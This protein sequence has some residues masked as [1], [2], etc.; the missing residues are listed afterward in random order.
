MNIN[1]KKSVIGN[2][3]LYP[4]LTGNQRFPYLNQR[5]RRAKP[6]VSKNPSGI[7]VPKTSSKARCFSNFPL[8]KR[9]GRKGQI[10]IFIILG[11]I[12][13]ISVITVIYIRG[14]AVKK[15]AEVE[16]VLEEVP[17]WVKPVQRYVHSCM[18]EVAIKAFKKIGEHGGY[19]DFD[20]Y[21]IVGRN[22]NINLQDPTDSDAVSLS[23]Q[24]SSPVAYWWYMSTPN[25]CDNCFVDSLM[26]TLEDVEQ[27][28]NRYINKELLICLDNFSTFRKQNFVFETGNI[29]TT[30]SV[31]IND[32]SV[33][34]N[35]PV[36]V[37]LADSTISMENFRINLD[38][39]FFRNFLLASLIANWEMD[40]QFLEEMIMY[41][42]TGYSSA[43]D[44]DRIPPISWID[45]EDSFVTWD[46]GKVKEVINRD[47]LGSNIPLI[48]V[49][50][51]GGATHVDDAMFLDFLNLNFPLQVSFFYDPVWNY[52]LD[53]TPSTGNILKPT[54]STID[55]PIGFFPEV[56]TNYYEFFYDVSF[57]VIVI[58]RDD[59]SL[60]AHGEKGYT[61]MFALEGNIRDNK[62]LYLWNQGR[63]TI[64]PMDYSGVSVSVGATDSSSTAC[65]QVDIESDD[66][67]TAVEW[68]CPLN[69]QDYTDFMACSSDCI[70]TTTS[71]ISP[72]RMPSLFCEHEQRI[73]GN[74]TIRTF[75]AE[76]NNP[77]P[78]VPITFGCGNYRKCL[79]GVTNDGGVYTDKF[80]MCV[81]SGY[82]LFDKSNY[83]SEYL[84]DI[85]I[86]P[87]EPGSYNVYLEPIVGKEVDAYFINVTNM[88]RL[89]RRLLP[90][91]GLGVLEELYHKE[92]AGYT[93]APRLPYYDESGILY[94]IEEAI[95]SLR[96]GS[97]TPYTLTGTEASI[98]IASINSAKEKIID[99]NSSLSAYEYWHQV[100]REKVAEAVFKTRAAAD[101]GWNILNDKDY[102][103]ALIGER[104][105]GEI[106][107]DV[108]KNSLLT[109]ILESLNKE[110]KNIQFLSDTEVN[111][112][113]NINSYRDSA[114]PFGEGDILIMTYQKVKEDM[115]E[116]NLPQA[117]TQIEYGSNGTMSLTPGDY[118]VNMIFVKGDGLT[119]PVYGN[120]PEVEDYPLAGGAELNNY[121]GFWSITKAQLDSGEHIRLYFFRTDDPITMEDI[122]EAGIIAN[123]SKRYRNYIE[124]EFLS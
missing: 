13:L 67:S 124:P 64:G 14:Q 74:I 21:E 93:P 117:V 37:K 108:D 26:P 69:N 72:T 33:N 3:I 8:G 90:D 2:K 56:T 34:V 82:L 42:V 73:S 121:T 11:F 122:G 109:D 39:G 43:L 91:T 70:T 30:A 18:E 80:P 23:T 103:K 12:M 92:V 68:F 95:D 102:V 107:I 45:H 114:T 59:V 71:T 112:P 105:K 46:K 65:E 79:M 54:I 66:G 52:Y 106:T 87:D 47:V 5:L 32:V 76:T 123:Y 17:D 113:A 50:N 57:P 62:D 100:E 10:T 77:L 38:L 96:V 9:R 28:V 118:I 101:I 58:I 84:E 4:I 120:Y 25:L 40:D 83:V 6:E 35:Y 94:E 55:D 119:I 31:N 89:K 61:F 88:F 97:V 110:I 22:F 19:I 49:N 15:E 36:D 53:I 63:G 115:Y 99:A 78:N 86:M 7:F 51:T 104:F 24:H 48:Q 16:A 44:K 20:D 1:V 81:G 111:N 29:N 85:S 60:R 27:Q 41:L 98:L 75:D 116:Q